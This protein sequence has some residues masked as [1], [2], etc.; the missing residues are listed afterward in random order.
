MN[1]L[2]GKDVPCMTMERAK[3]LAKGPYDTIH[4]DEASMIDYLHL[5]A[6]MRL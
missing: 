1:K 4:V 2:N 3:I 6:L 5:A